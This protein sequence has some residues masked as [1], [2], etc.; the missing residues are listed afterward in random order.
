MKKTLMDGES[1]EWM[2]KCLVSWMDGWLEEMSN[3][4]EMGKLVMD[5]WIGM[6]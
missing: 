5:E 4:A 1:D 6:W 3:Q 2:N